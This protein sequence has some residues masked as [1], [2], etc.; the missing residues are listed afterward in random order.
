MNN[1]RGL[2]KGMGIGYKNLVPLDRHIHSLSAKG[3]KTL[4][5]NYRAMTD[6][7]F[8]A[9]K[10]EGFIDNAKALLEVNRRH[11]ANIDAFKRAGDME[12]L[13][14]YLSDY[15]LH[16]KW[17][18]Q[19]IKTIYS[20]GKKLKASGFNTMGLKRAIPAEN[21]ASCRLWPCFMFLLK[22]SRKTTASFIITPDSA[23]NP[24]ALSNDIGIPWT[25]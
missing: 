8:F 11:K 12:G 9:T 20:K 15:N 6:E 5:A 7:Q 3:V 21:A 1:R 22:R 25:P 18:R 17:A 4:N 2:G 13:N 10:P 23:T 14:Q 19:G 16:D 24:Q